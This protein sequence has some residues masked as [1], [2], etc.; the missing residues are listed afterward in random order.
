MSVPAGIDGHFRSTQT[1]EAGTSVKSGTPFPIS[2]AYGMIIPSESIICLTPYFPNIQPMTVQNL[3]FSEKAV[4]NILL[5]CLPGG[6]LFVNKMNTHKHVRAFPT[7]L[8]MDISLQQKKGTCTHSLCRFHRLFG[9]QTVDH[10]TD[11]VWVC[12][13]E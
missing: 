13:S 3:L 11:S 6:E 8:P 4:G 2:L 7:A 9:D 10:G 1:A 12:S 5:F